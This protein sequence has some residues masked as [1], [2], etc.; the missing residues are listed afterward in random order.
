MDN[1]PIWVGPLNKSLGRHLFVMLPS[2]MVGLLTLAQCGQDV[3]TPITTFLLPIIHKLPGNGQSWLWQLQAVELARAAAC[4]NQCVRD[5]RAHI[6]CQKKPGTARLHSY[7]A[8][9]SATNP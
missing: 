4:P 7:Q 2:L 1:E 9:R 3:H 5:S 8:A 6:A